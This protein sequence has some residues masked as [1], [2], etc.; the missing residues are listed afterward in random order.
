METTTR[1]MVKPSTNGKSTPTL[2]KA[3][4]SEAKPTASKA[5]AEAPKSKPVE[6]T[7]EKQPTQSA[8]MTMPTEPKAEAKVLPLVSASDRL[9][10]LE[11][12]QKLGNRYQLL[13]DKE[14]ELQ[15][16]KISQSGV[17]AQIKLECEG[18]E[19]KISNT[20]VIEKVLN[21]CMSELSG[22]LAT[23]EKEIREFNI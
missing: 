3:A 18:A 7:S 12:F 21:L 19:V 13:K 10:K 5:E 23:A 16:F 14:T 2:K 1:P 15:N 6:K 4:Q 17:L 11:Q 20:Q 22:F 8:Q 9:A